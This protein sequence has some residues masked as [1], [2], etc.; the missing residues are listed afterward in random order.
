MNNFNIE[1]I[2]DEIFST[3]SLILAVFSSPRTSQTCMKISCRPIII[4]SQLT[5]QI[6]YHNKDKALH[7]NFSPDEA[8]R[9]IFG[10]IQEKFKQGVL[11][12]SFTDYHLLVNKKNHMTILKKPPTQQSLPL[13]HNRAKQ[14]LLGEGKPIPFLVELGVMTREGKVVAKKSDKFRQINRFLEMVDD[15]LPH[16]SHDHP[17]QIIDFG[18]GK[19]Y[20]TFA[21]YHFLHNVKNYPLKLI[22]LD[23]KESVIAD[24]LQIAKKLQYQNLSFAVGDIHHYKPSEKVDMVITLHACDTATDA[25]LA[26]AVKW[27]S[28]VI[29]SVPCCQHELY[30]QVANEQ[31]NPLLKHGILKER[32]AALATDA[33][34]AQLLEVAGYQV[35]VLEFI[36]M[37]HTPKN[38][39]IRAVRRASNPNKSRLIKQYQ[40]FKKV[41]SITPCLEKLLSYTE[42]DSKVDLD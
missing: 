39:L 25:A 12:T 34:R 13:T 22:G 2:L 3:N 31:F 14:Y 42:C 15:I 16:L 29:L 21:L 32:F 5:Y 30:D 19:S 24:C 28:D 8:R 27:E 33:A 10:A 7:K 35:Q 1:Q 37:E 6:T 26:T 40:E 23:L 17:L 20:L 9:I 36:D 38:L 11:F 4:K 41:L 18:C